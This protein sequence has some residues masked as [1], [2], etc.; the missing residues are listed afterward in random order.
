MRY[1]TFYSM[2]RRDEV[3]VVDT[4]SP[5]GEPATVEVFSG[6]YAAVDAEH[7]ADALNSFDARVADAPQFMPIF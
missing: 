2:V 5:I 6:R 4:S 1:V 7:L 3:F